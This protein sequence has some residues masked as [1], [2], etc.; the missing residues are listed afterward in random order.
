MTDGW[1]V[2]PRPAPP[3]L[4]EDFTA[5]PYRDPFMVPILEKLSAADRDTL[6][7]LMGAWPIV[8]S[9]D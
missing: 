3:E 6:A 2:D 4:A 1:V 7:A 9:D 5:T 8:P